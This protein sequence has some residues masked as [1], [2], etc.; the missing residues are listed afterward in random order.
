M[1]R[2]SAKQNAGKGLL[3]IVL[4]CDLS[5]LFLSFFLLEEI[6][7]WYLHS[8]L[9]SMIY[10]KA[11]E[12]QSRCGEQNYKDMSKCT[13]SSGKAFTS[14]KLNPILVNKLSNC[15]LILVC[16]RYFQ[17]GD[18]ILVEN[19]KIKSQSVTIINFIKVQH[20]QSG[21]TGK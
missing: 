9:S 10:S 1:A 14:M 13:N 16:L 11:N 19:G 6:R 12:K 4:Y 7:I 2:Q 5:F 21:I 17:L 3:Y 8:I 18:N 20:F 15:S